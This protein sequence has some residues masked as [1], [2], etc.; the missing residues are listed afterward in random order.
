MLRFHIEAPISPAGFW[1]LRSETSGTLREKLN[2][3]SDEE[4]EQTAQEVEEAA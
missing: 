3:L 1:E 4:K 2:M